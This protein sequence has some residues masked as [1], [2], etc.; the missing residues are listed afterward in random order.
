MPMKIANPF[1]I[2]MD[3]DMEVIMKGNSS[4]IFGSICLVLSQSELLTKGSH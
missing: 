2:S 4:R 3:F 1:Y